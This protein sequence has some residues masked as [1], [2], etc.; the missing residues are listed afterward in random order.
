MHRNGAFA[1]VRRSHCLA[2]TVIAGSILVGCVSPSLDT[3]TSVED[4]LS[5]WTR[6]IDFSRQGWYAFLIETERA[7][8]QAFLN[9]SALEAPSFDSL[10]FL[11][12]DGAFYGGYTGWRSLGEQGAYAEARV[13]PG[14]SPR[15]DA[16]QNTKTPDAGSAA[17]VAV[18]TPEWEDPV[19]E[20]FYI[21]AWY[22]AEE[23]T[24]NLTL[25]GDAGSRLLAESQGDDVFVAT[26][27]DF[28]GRGQVQA[29]PA[30]YLGARAAVEGTIPLHVNHTFLGFFVESRTAAGKLSV[31]LPDRTVQACEEVAPMDPWKGCEVRDA[32]AWGPGDY[33]FRL[34]DAGGG[35]SFDAEVMLGGA[36]VRLPAPP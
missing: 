29:Y 19:T 35:Y 8:V 15:Y 21:V 5:G 7:Q 6:R 9:T 2:L 32:G 23:P 30:R 16:R 13:A 12:E 31:T 18:N 4:P 10:W 14:V 11:A 28:G 1:Q 3:E 27:I 22:A 25:V 36:D 24:G 33:V 17:W 26:S 20:R 34:D